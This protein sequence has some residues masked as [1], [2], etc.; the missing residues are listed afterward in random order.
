MVGC[1][2]RG[3]TVGLTRLLALSIPGKG[4]REHLCSCA[5]CRQRG[6]PPGE[7]AG[8][9]EHAGRAEHVCTGEHAGTGEQVGRGAHA[10]RAEQ[11]EQACTVEATRVTA[12]PTP[13]SPVSGV[14]AASV[15]PDTAAA[16]ASTTAARLNEHKRMARSVRSSM[17]AAAESKL[18]WR[19]AAQDCGLRSGAPQRCLSAAPLVGH[20]ALC[21]HLKCADDAEDHDGGQQHASGGEL[22]AHEHPIGTQ[23]MTLAAPALARV[24]RPAAEEADPDP[25]PRPS[26]DEPR[27]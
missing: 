9:G 8:T 15:L 21:V 12:L 18:L 20:E 16:A 13:A 1:P 23:R 25:A 26:H 4:S 22:V 7:Q 17:W 3:C 11:A 10:G 6:Q 27:G 2:S 5:R 19:A 24:P 14:K